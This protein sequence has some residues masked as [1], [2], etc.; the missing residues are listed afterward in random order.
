MAQLL[1]DTRMRNF[2]IAQRGRGRDRRC[3]HGAIRGVHNPGLAVALKQGGYKPAAGS[4]R[5]NTRRR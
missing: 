4:N 1:H 5:A 3:T 2:I